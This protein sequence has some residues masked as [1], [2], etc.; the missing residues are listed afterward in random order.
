MLCRVLGD[1][2]G[3]TYSKQPP[4]KRPMSNLC[5]RVRVCACVRACVR[6]FCGLSRAHAGS[7]AGQLAS[8][9]LQV[10]RVLGAQRCCWQQAALV[11]GCWSCRVGHHNPSGQL[12]IVFDIATDSS[13]V[14]EGFHSATAASRI[15]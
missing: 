11:T 9:Q 2:R 12:L 14:H 10:L 6:A 5:V 7:S 4:C 15:G 3:R 13:F 1:G 8:S